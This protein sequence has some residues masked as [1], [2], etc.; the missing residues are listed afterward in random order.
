MSPPRLAWAGLQQRPRVPS[1]GL[2]LTDWR[3]RSVGE[4]LRTVELEAN[5]FESAFAMEVEPEFPA[6]GDRGCEVIGFDRDGNAVG[7]FVSR[8]GAPLVARIDPAAGP[9]WVAMFAAGGLGSFRGVFA[10]PA[11]TELAVVVDGLASW[12]RQRSRHPR[13]RRSSMA[14]TLSPPARPAAAAPRDAAHI[15]ALGPSDVAWRTPRL[16]LDEL[17]VRHA[18]R[19]GIICSV[20]NSAAGWGNGEIVLDPASGD[21]VAG[22]RFDSLWP[23]EAPRSAWPLAWAS[24]REC[25]LS[26]L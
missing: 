19:D 16:C 24:V 20:D 2:R 25:P 13:R 3:R 26:D 21:Q 22:T 9:A 23:P 11:S 10:T 6:A 1:T 15:L 18:D 7:D 8:W 12:L 17:H 5:G 14:F 4:I